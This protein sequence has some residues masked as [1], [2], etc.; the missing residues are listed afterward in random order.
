MGAFLPVPCVAVRLTAGLL[1]AFRAAAPDARAL[2]SVLPEM[3]AVEA[4]SPCVELV[5]QN[6]E[7]I[8]LEQGVVG[9]NPL[10]EQN[11]AAAEIISGQDRRTA[12]SGLP[13]VTKYTLFG[14]FLRC[15]RQVHG[16][17]EWAQIPKSREE[18]AASRYTRQIKAN[19]LVCR[20]ATEDSFLSVNINR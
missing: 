11:R 20:T 12:E 6:I 8:Q 7:D 9:T 17:P 15:L 18:A 19:V 1:F 4:V 2:N 10:R 16:L 14:V 13:K 3:K 5:T